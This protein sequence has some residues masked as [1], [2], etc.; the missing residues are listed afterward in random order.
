MKRF[1]KRNHT[2]GVTTHAERNSPTFSSN[3]NNNRPQQQQQQHHILDHK[4]SD[5]PGNKNGTVTSSSSFH[6]FTDAAPTNVNGSVVYSP[7]GSKHTTTTNTYS[8]ISPRMKRIS[9]PFV[10]AMD[11]FVCLC[12]LQALV[13]YLLSD[14][15]E[16]IEEGEEDSYDHNNHNHIS[17]L[18]TQWKELSSSTSFR[19]QSTF[20]ATFEEFESIPC[21]TT[22][23]QEE[24]DV[25]F[26]LAIPLIEKDLEKVP[27][28]C[29]RWGI[30]APISI[31]VWTDL[32]PTQIAH[33]LFSFPSSICHPD[34]MTITTLASTTTTA[35]AI[36]NVRN[37]LRN[38]AIQGATTTHVLPIDIHMWTSVDLYETLNTPKV[39]QTLAND[40]HQ[41]ILIPAFEMN[42]EACTE[43]QNDNDKNDNENKKKCHQDVPRNFDDLI[44]HLGEKSV[45][46]MDPMDYELQ[47]NADYKSWVRQSRS[48]LL[49]IDCVSPSNRF[50]P[51]LVVRKCQHLPPFQE[52]LSTTTDQNSD[53]NVHAN[54]PTWIAQLI[55]TGYTMKQ[56]GGEFVV[57]LPPKIVTDPRYGG[58]SDEMALSSSPHTGRA[59][60]RGGPKTNMDFFRWLD[61]SVPNR[62]VVSV[63]QDEDPTTPDHSLSISMTKLRHGTADVQILSGYET[64]RVALLTTA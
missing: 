8:S 21:T 5:S 48:S 16:E 19:R 63:C 59:A 62:R 39:R 55:H 30:E 31:A 17:P 57:Y 38:L 4:R 24:Q 44:V 52:I 43:Q 29:R 41:T 51:F 25:S 47:G 14:G 23:I 13:I 12:L 53:C 22:P 15:H 54:D 20:Q 46:P 28:H 6:F 49:S 27:H 42:R 18:I 32:S 36:G 56:L 26:T 61:R 2:A 64:I 11:F 1:S 34:Q 45:Y 50:Q 60:G 40:P 35:T 10:Y 58:R 7:K 3:I 9:K 33:K 37:R